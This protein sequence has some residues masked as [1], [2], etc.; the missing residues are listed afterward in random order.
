[1]ILDDIVRAKRDEIV[2]HQRQR[3]LDGVRC[4]VELL[5]RSPPRLRAALRRAGSRASSRK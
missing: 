4:D 2:E 5:P 3:P 1:M